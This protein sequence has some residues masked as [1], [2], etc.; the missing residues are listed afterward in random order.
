MSDADDEVPSTEPEVEEEESETASRRKAQGSIPS[1][2]SSGMALSPISIT[3]TDSFP[4][5][6]SVVEPLFAPL[7]SVEEEALNAS[8]AQEHIISFRKSFFRK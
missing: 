2:S 7:A 1:C 8:A 5:P 3:S 4:A 6:Q